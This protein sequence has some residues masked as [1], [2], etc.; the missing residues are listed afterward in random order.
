[1]QEL[2]SKETAGSRSSFVPA[3]ARVF[4]P[5]QRADVR[6]RVV[7]GETVILD[8]REE[9]IHQFNKT[10]SFIWSHCNG[11]NTPDEISRALCEAFDVDFPTARRDALAT[12]EQLRR[13]KLLEDG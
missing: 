12:V 13:A 3:G 2:R 4:R 1:M 6:T 11:L 9:F 5:K 8:R 10:A 7:E